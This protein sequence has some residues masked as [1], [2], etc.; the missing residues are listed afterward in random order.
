MTCDAV[1]QIVAAKADRAWAPDVAAHLL[2]CDACLSLAIEWMLEDS[3]DG[4]PPPAFA[5]LVATAAERT[6]TPSRP[7]RRGV[8]VAV[9]AVIVFVLATG[10][11]VTARLDFSFGSQLSWSL[12]MLLGAVAEAMVLI[13]WMTQADGLQIR[14][15]QRQRS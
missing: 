14:T 15:R 12:A 8:I 6:G 1:R 5:S 10:P 11:W 4:T 2:E 13:G 9:V 7:P 3:P